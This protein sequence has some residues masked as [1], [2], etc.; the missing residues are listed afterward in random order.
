MEYLQAEF[1]ISCSL[2]LLGVARDLLA[3]AAGEAGF[4]S[5]EETDW[6]LTGYVQPDFFDRESLDEAIAAFPLED[7]MITYEVSEAENKDWNE[8]WE[9]NGFEPISVDNS[10]AVP[11]NAKAS[12]PTLPW[13]TIA[14]KPASSESAEADN[15]ELTIL[16]D[17][18]LAFGTGT[19]ETT[20]MILAT[21]M[22]L[23]LEGKRILDCGCGTGILGI[24]ACRLG[25][26]DVVGYDIDEWSVENT[27]HNAA[28]NRVNITAVKGDASVLATVEGNFDIV[29]ANINRNILLADMPAMRA[30][31]TGSGLLI[32]S[33]FYKPDLEML[34][35]KA[36]TLGL[37]L[38]G[39]R[40]ENEWCCAVFSA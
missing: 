21:L 10:F 34:Q 33:G 37:Q 27:T 12:S 35:E 30:K 20:R 23:P 1:K 17:P 31:L 8:V 18:R 22:T 4:E 9:Q 2:E 38:Q 39:Q 16:I 7:T 40:T 3:D 13:Q 11:V 29:M 26:A 19:H 36:A 15:S 24:T 28:L 32:L 14:I 25:A 6:G 5:F